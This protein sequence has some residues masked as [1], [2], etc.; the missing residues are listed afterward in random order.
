MKSKVMYNKFLRDTKDIENYQTN[1]TQEEYDISVL[2]RINAGGDTYFFP[3][4]FLDF[5]ENMVHDR[6]GKH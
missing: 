3:I 2:I 6:F 5:E 4:Y 1:S